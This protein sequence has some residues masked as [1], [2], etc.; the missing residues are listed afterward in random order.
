M[1]RAGAAALT[2]TRRQATI[3]L[4]E[5][6]LDW[7]E[8]HPGAQPAQLPQIA[9][10]GVGSW[11]RCDRCATTGRVIGSGLAAKPC[12][13]AHIQWPYEHNCRPCAACDNGWKRVAGEGS[14]RM[15]NAGKHDLH[16]AVMVKEESRLARLRENAALAR[17][18]AAPHKTDKDEI[19]ETP[20]FRWERE[21]DRHYRHGDYAALSTALAWL[22]EQSPTAHQLVT[23]VYEYRII[24]QPAQPVAAAAL[25]GVDVLAARM[26]DP[27]R[28]PDWLVPKHPAAARVDKRKAAAA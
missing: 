3:I 22:L 15:L 19:A 6:R 2:L 25:A 8:F 18:L 10:A 13:G 21:R 23:W 17:Q 26:P 14:D 7:H 20:P 5:S 4:L 24:R 1:V 28:V 12:R 16:S 11:E 27:I 9:K